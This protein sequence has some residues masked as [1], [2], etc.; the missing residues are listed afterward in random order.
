MS[1]LYRVEI[2]RVSYQQAEIEVEADNE[3]DA[4]DMALEAVRDDMFV[5]READVHVA[6]VE[7]LQILVIPPK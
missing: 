6:D 1:K 2:A 7:P 4:T 5:Q 3:H